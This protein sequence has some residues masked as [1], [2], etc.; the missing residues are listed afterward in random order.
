MTLAPLRHCKICLVALP[1]EHYRLYDDS[2]ASKSKLIDKTSAFTVARC[3]YWLRSDVPYGRQEKRAS[4]SDCRQ[5]A[6]SSGSRRRIFSGLARHA[7]KRQ[8]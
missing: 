7:C 3:D 8:G 5:L 2:F 4:I 1:R 6:P